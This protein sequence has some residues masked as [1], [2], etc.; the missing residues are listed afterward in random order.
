MVKYIPSKLFGFA[1]GQG[2][3]VFFHLGNF[4]PGPSVEQIVFCD[5]CPGCLV[6]TDPPP[7]ILGELVDVQVD[8]TQS[9]EGKAPRA[10]RVDRVAV[11][12]LLL[13]TVET[14][15][16]RRGFGFMMSEGISYHLHESEIIDGR[17]PLAGEQVLFYPGLRE[18][19]PRACHVRVCR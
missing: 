3:D 5:S 12:D 7:P 14:F 2:F 16:S 13:G 9:T 8:I 11:S 19:K 15:D 6:T 1:R 17:M 4:H 10:S 18:G